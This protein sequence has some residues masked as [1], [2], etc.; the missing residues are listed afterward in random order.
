VEVQIGR[1]GMKRDSRQ[2]GIWLDLE[3]KIL[4]AISF[5]KILS[6]KWL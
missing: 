4:V 2:V 3:G 5:K 6:D 1:K